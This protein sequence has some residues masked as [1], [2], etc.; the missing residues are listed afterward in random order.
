M[1]AGQERYHSLTKAF[2]RGSAGAMLVYDVTRRSTFDSIRR[3]LSVGAGR[4]GGRGGG[5][6]ESGAVGIVA[7]AGLEGLTFSFWAAVFGAHPAEGLG[8]FSFKPP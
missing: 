1:C 4:L 6:G 3:W 2:Y 5:G 8:C 7:G